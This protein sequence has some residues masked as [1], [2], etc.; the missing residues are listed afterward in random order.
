M[1]TCKIVIYSIAGRDYTDSLCWYAERSNK[2]ASDYDS[3]SDAPIRTI[4]AGTQRFPF[5]D[6]RH[7]FFLMQTF[8]V[9]FRVVNEAIH[10]VAVV[11]T[12]R[13]SNNWRDQYLLQ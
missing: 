1:L 6:D 2:A 10:I 11:H 4:L 8:Q 5:C 13:K 3:D 9:I 7:Q 12:A